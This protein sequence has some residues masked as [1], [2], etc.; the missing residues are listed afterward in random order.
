MLEE[1]S[2]SIRDEYFKKYRMNESKLLDSERI[3]SNFRKVKTD[4]VDKKELTKIILENFFVQFTLANVLFYN[5]FKYPYTTSYPYSE[6]SPTEREILKKIFENI[7]L[8]RIERDNQIFN[9]LNLDSPLDEAVDI[10]MELYNQGKINKYISYFFLDNDLSFNYKFEKIT[11]YKYVTSEVKGEY[12][13]DKK[14]LIKYLSDNIERIEIFPIV[15]N[16]RI[17]ELENDEFLDCMYLTY[18]ILILELMEDKSKLSRTHITFL[19]R[20]IASNN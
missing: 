2:R 3:V 12:T 7:S 18:D 11:F 10:F 14:P 15:V 13:P 17:E 19:K 16:K 1:I 9:S 8:V 5:D 4:K 6:V 20:N